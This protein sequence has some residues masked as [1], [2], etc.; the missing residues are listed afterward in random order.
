MQTSVKKYVVYLHRRNDTGV[1]F[2]VGQGTPSRPKSKTRRRS[3]RLAT[4]YRNKMAE[5]LELK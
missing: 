1:V 5:H 2:Y 4:E 3:L